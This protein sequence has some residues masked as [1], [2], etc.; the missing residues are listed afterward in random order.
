MAWLARVFSSSIGKKQLVAVTG[1]GLCGFLIAHLSGNF[2]LFA[3]QEAFD[4]YAKM[5]LLFSMAMTG[6]GGGKPLQN[7]LGLPG[8]HRRRPRLDTTTPEQLHGARA[9]LAEIGIEELAPH[10]ADSQD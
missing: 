3:G 7:A 4:A 1:L 2:L 5:L 9:R 6:V 10:L 8:G